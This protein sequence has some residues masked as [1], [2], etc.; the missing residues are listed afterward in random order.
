MRDSCVYVCVWKT[1]CITS[2][3]MKSGVKQTFVQHERLAHSEE[4]HNG[5]RPVLLHTLRWVCEVPEHS[6]THTSLY[7][8]CT[9]SLNIALLVSF[10]SLA[11][12][13]C[14]GKTASRSRDWCTF[15]EKMYKYTEFV[16]A[17]FFPRAELKREKSKTYYSCSKSSVKCLQIWDLNLSRIMY[18]TSQVWQINACW[19]EGMPRHRCA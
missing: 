2:F 19:L 6:L 11:V 1:L 3:D 14:A 12:M 16:F 15:K 17:L 13:A 5:N 8:L 9:Q 18:L 7:T 4:F 10:A